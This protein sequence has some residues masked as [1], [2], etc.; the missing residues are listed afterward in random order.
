MKFV[1]EEIDFLTQE[2][3]KHITE[4]II[5]KASFCFLHLLDVGEKS[6]VFLHELVQR[7]ERADPNLPTR[8]NSIYTEFFINIL[9]RF[10]KKHNLP[11]NRILR[12]V[13]NVTASIKDEISHIHLDHTFP[14]SQFILYIGENIT[15]DILLY[16]EDEKTLVKRISPANFK[17][18]CFGDTAIP[19]QFYYP[20]I[21]YRIAVVITFD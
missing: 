12:A 6:P 18:V 13:V 2:E 20:E 8:N 17:I 16:E 3:K 7:I 11:L 10:T 15:G 9:E 19:H 21:G 5:P 1:I 4:E 14:H